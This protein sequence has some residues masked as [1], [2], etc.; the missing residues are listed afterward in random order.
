MREPCPGHIIVTITT[1]NGEQMQQEILVELVRA[2]A[3]PEGESV[4]GIIVDGGG[5]KPFV[6]ERGWSG[7]AGY[8]LEQWSIRRGG[9]EV[10]Y[11]SEPRQIF[12]RGVQSVTNY[13]DTVTGRIRLEPGNYQ[14]V[15][16]IDGMFMG[17]VEVQARAGGAAAA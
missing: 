5:T 3:R 16:L 2:G 6:V 10:L 12:V 9:R 17:H 1:R 7:P 11:Q 4:E 14:L 8:Y 13:T 15:F